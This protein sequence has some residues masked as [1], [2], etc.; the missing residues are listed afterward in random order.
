MI[1]PSQVYTSLTY[2][3]VL[4]VVKKAGY[5]IIGFRQPNL[6]ETYLG[7]PNFSILHFI[8][9]FD[10]PSYRVGNGMRLILERVEE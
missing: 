4:T 2:E 5:K 8:S 9:D 6:G 1:R 10:G 3:E 7:L